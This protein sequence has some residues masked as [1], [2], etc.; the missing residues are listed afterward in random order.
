MAGEF[1]IGPWL[2][3][4]RLNTISRNGSD[5]HLE[6]K[7][8]D[9]LVCLADNYGQTVSREELLRT[10]WPNTFVTDDAL[11]RC[12]SELRRVFEDHAHDPHTIETIP[13]RGYRVIATVQTISEQAERGRLP[14]RSGSQVRSTT[15][16]SVGREKERAELAA[17]FG[18]A[19]H[20]G[21]LLVCVAGEPGIGKTT[22]VEDFLAE[23]E[24]VGE[25]FHLA[26]GRCSQRLAGSEAYL[27]FLEALEDL[28]RED[29]GGN[30]QKLRALA[31][32]WYAQ[33][34]PLSDTDP[35]EV[36][37]QEYVTHSTQERVKREL[38]SFIREIARQVPVILFFDDLHW[39]DASTVDLLNHLA[40]KF[41]GTKILVIVTYRPSELFQ[42]KHSFINV[43][44]DL[45]SRSTCREIAV[46]FLTPE[47]VECYIALE[48]PGNSFPHA[49]ATMIHSRTEGNPLFM[50]DLL[51]YLRSRT[52]IAE[53]EGDERWKLAQS[54]PNLRGVLP[55][56][57]R[58]MIERKLDEVSQSDRDV[59]TAA[60]VEGFE[61]D[62]ASIARALQNE[63]HAVEER[64]ERLDR[65]H[66]FV[67]RVGEEEFP[68][69]TVALRCR[70]VHVLYQDA[71]YATIGPNRRT[72][73]SA[74]LA[75][76][77]EAF[78][79][80]RGP[81]I[82]SR[83][84]FLYEDARDSARASDYFL[85]A[86]QQAQRIFANQEAIA[87]A[88]RGLTQ[89][90]KLPDTPE[91]ARR[92]LGLQITLA[93][94][95][96]WTQGYASPE[97]GASM[98]RARE[99]CE[100]LG[101][102]A[103][104]FPVIFGLFSY[105][106]CKGD[107]RPTR[108]TAEQLS[109]IARSLNDTVLLVGAHTALGFTFHHEGELLACRQQFEEA[110]RLHVVSQHS[111]Y[112]Q[113]Y[114][115]DPGIHAQCERFWTL[116][117]LGYPDQARR[118]ME[119]SLRLADAVSSPLSTAFARL[120][121]TYVYQVLRL[122]NETRDSAE[123]CMAVCEEHAIMLE[124]TWVQCPYGWAIAE[125]GR[126][127]EGLSHIRTSL[128][129]QLCIGAQIARPHFQAI[130]A[131]ALLHAGRVAAAVQAIEDGLAAS[132]RNGERTY[133]A[134]LWRLKGE[135]LKM[136]GNMAD[137][138]S[139]FQKAIEIARQQAARSLELRA[140]T[141]LARVWQRQNK[142]AE[143]RQVLGEIYS[144][145]TEGFD[146]ADLGEAASLLADLS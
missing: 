24:T 119:Q 63:C 1:R 26:R 57:A 137:A 115:F 135:L 43:R 40:T 13:K 2:V 142:R 37:L 128:D 23:L 45:L 80:D 35:S 113:L 131:D 34:F 70:F 5:L 102:T 109:N 50:A 18:S 71:L 73:L 112:M 52:I 124:R 118:N 136:Q 17:A 54:V 76:A 77:L 138:E 15:G 8:M 29:R 7:V 65:I 78:Y 121:E 38:A 31:P 20:G 68:D 36:R 104:L 99:L 98:A 123:A 39:A 6:P 47:D 106:L 145:F 25:P 46:E 116:W 62:S 4:P 127:E 132:I 33:L 126:I 130:S 69:G 41:A 100:A 91:R 94:A 74:A 114:K 30:R 14:L 117:L 60:A 48:F 81:A 120:F 96:L 19:T 83:L 61:F 42:W 49:F 108:E 87:L 95:L 67:R 110:C 97:T 58:S 103:S 11:T 146:T 133:D 22:L 64:L 105:Y 85:L 12:I 56:S 122:P 84:G 134:E 32:S 75:H 55:E 82:A 107:V 51:R 79:G 72:V 86:A 111:R 139:C 129:T 53:T 27:P 92:E 66:A 143:A 28:L 59:L 89:L 44:R 125:L 101:D 93:F 9:V 144:W 141:S 88:R 140:S 21:G 3:T 16:H 90:K 10:V